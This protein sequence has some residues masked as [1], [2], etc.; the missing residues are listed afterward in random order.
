MVAAS[1]YELYGEIWGEGAPGFE[2]ELG[3]SLEPR[4]HD[5]LYELFGRCGIPSDGLVLD[6]G[7]R[8]AGHAVELAKRFG[9]RCLAIDPVPRHQEW[10][11]KSIAE[12][13]LGDRVTAALAA[14]EALPCGDASIDA[15]W[16]RDVLNHVD[17]PRAFAECARVLK[18]GG[19]LF[20]YV[21]LATERMEPREAARLYPSMAIVPDNMNPARVEEHARSV[22]FTIESVDRIDSEWREHALEQGDAWKDSSP[23]LLRLARMRRREAELVERYGRAFYEAAYGSDLWGI[24]QLLGKLCPTV[25]VLRK[26]S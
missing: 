1:I 6:A 19:P 18:P 24:Y 2:E 14:I 25:Y 23:A 4:S 10:M 7:S 13:A 12:A 20:V 26:A 11:S 15:I 16:C 3:R 5:C 22:G 17:L 9:C 21:T 8:D